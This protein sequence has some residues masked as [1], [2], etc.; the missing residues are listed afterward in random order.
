MPARG[1]W[2]LVGR[3]DELKSIEDVVS[4]QLPG[5]VLVGDA[6]VG[7]TR[8]LREAMT[9]AAGDGVECHWVSATGAARSIPFG[10]VS[11]LIPAPT[12]PRA[13]PVGLV[14]SVE[15]DF[16]RRGGGRPVLIGIDDAHLLDEPSAGLLHQLAVH[17][18]ATAV[19]TVRSGEP[20]S[21]A[22]TSL[23]AGSGRRLDVRPLP[24]TAVDH[25]L[26]EA[27]PGPLDAI[28]RR[29][30]TRLA[31]GNPLL[32]RELLADAMDTGGLVESRGVW[33][34]RGTASGSPRL[35]ELVSARLRALEPAARQV[36]EVVAC[37]EPLSLTLLE[38]FTD[39]AAIEA[40][41]RSGMAVAERSGARTALRMAHPL[42][43]EALRASMPASRSRT[44]FGQLADVLASMPLRRRDDAL[45]AGVWQLR[46]GSVRHPG[47]AL[48]AARQAIDRFDIDLAERLA[49]TAYDAEQGWEA[50]WLLARVLQYQARSQEAFDMLPP[51]PP[52][53][54][55][56][57]AIWAITR[58]GLLYWGLDRIDE[59]HETLAM[60]PAGSPGHDLTEATRSWVLFYDGRCEAALDVGQAVLTR[61]DIGVRA[62]SW[63]TMGAASAAGMLGRLGLAAELAERGRAVLAAEPER[64]PWNEAQVGLGLCYA[65][66][67]A[68]ELTGAAELADQ[69]YR[70]AV[71][72]D[73]RGMVAVWAGFRGIIGKT[74]GR[75][76]AAEADLREAIALVE[77]ND[78]YHLVRTYWAELAGVRALAGDVPGARRWLAAADARERAANRIFHPWVELNRAWVEAAEGDLTAA[79]RTA[80]NAA[81][82]ARGSEQP[83]IEAVALYECAR[84]GAPEPVRDRLVDLAGHLGGLASTLASAADGLLREDGETLET[85]A[86][87]LVARGHTLLAAEVLGAAARAYARHGRPRVAVAQR[88]ATLAQ[89]CRPVRTPL[90]AATAPGAEQATLTRRE[91]DV[92]LLA[93][94][95]PSRSIADRLGLSVNT[96][97][98]NL[99][100]VFTKLGVRN[101]HEL[102]VVLGHDQPGAGYRSP[103][104]IRSPQ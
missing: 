61:P 97:N 93:V 3:D 92:A 51:A 29:R 90:L 50:Q 71:A 14:V 52:P 38:R 53:G 83:T 8:L 17:G 70:D 40:A 57:L 100:R 22:L 80:R 64:L 89:K 36:L 19:A 55:K 91:R 68:G 88:A 94:A 95:L 41:E 82:L 74:Q 25:L 104:A 69:G 32:L 76:A 33:R 28:S 86:D 23:W 72:S 31:D 81:D 16:A 30:L 5:L 85:A 75:L 6:G 20:L 13:D 2:P 58:A 26:D 45:V 73:A 37:G 7:K 62:A 18:L 99:A 96:V 66:Y 46:S 103:G 42:Y 77:E 9:R 43:G 27:A 87:D 54:S 4:A 49:R 24:A 48:A 56:R 35:A 21:D 39:S 102:A 79:I 47:I 84:L 101:R 10:A 60:V 98:N 34:W 63:A 59:A 12:R 1:E 65:R 11:H 78:Q 67:A 44:V 15:R